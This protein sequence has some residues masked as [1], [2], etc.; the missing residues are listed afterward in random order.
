MKKETEKKIFVVTIE[1]TCTQDV[2]I[3][4][5]SL[6]T[7]MEFAEELYHEGEIILAPGSLIK[8]RMVAYE[9]GTGEHTEWR[10]FK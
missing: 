4:A 9:V 8:K 2:K 6:E 10:E 1:E 3:E 7:A 5:S